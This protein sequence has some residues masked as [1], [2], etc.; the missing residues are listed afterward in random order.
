MA[1][2][3]LEG[4]PPS[5]RVPPGE[6][7]STRWAEAEGRSVGPDLMSRPKGADVA[8]VAMM[9]PEIKTVAILLP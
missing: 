9:R 7:V 4:T 1:S 5:A 6:N 3:D 8:C 2:R